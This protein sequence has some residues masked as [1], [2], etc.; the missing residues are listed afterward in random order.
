[1]SPLSLSNVQVRSNLL[2][3][4][5]F[6]EDMYLQCTIWELKDIDARIP[7]DVKTKLPDAKLDEWREMLFWPLPTPERDPAWPEEFAAAIPAAL[8]AAELRPSEEDAFELLVVVRQLYATRT[9]ATGR[10]E[11]ADWYV[12]LLAVLGRDE[13]KLTRDV[14]EHRL[15][16]VFGERLPGPPAPALPVEVAATPPPQVVHPPE[17][18]VA[19]PVRRK[20]PPK[21]PA[22]VALAEKPSLPF[23]SPDPLPASVPPAPAVDADLE[24]V[25]ARWTCLPAHVKKSILLLVKAA[26]HLP[27]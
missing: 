6:M 26:E 24:L 23:P 21:P 17:A 25:N 13:F 7:D 1:M 20:S 4:D 15:A 3:F 14:I 16:D 5:T 10:A 19:K 11:A 9:E 2:P 27:E 18:A 12:R 8:A 22:A